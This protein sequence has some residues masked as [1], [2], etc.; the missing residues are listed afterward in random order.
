MKESVWRK[1]LCFTLAFALIIGMMPAIP[2]AVQK[3][4]ATTTIT[5][6]AVD[7]IAVPEIGETP[8]YTASVPDGAA[9]YIGTDITWT[10]RDVNG[11]LW[12]K[13]ENITIDKS[14]TF[15]ED[16]S[17]DVR[18][19][20][21]AKDGSTFAAKENLTVTINGQPAHI[22]DS[23]TEKMLYIRYTFGAPKGKELIDSVALT[24]EGHK[25]GGKVRG[26]TFTSND[27]IK[28]GSTYGTEENYVVYLSDTENPLTFETSVFCPWQQY[29]V[30]Y[31][32][33][34]M[35]GYTF[36]NFGTLMADEVTLN[37][38]PADSLTLQND[39]RIRALFALE[40][41]GYIHE[42]ELSVVKPAS[43]QPIEKPTVVSVNGDPN[44]NNLVSASYSKW[45]YSPFFVDGAEYETVSG[46]AF[47]D[48]YA[49]K[50]ELDALCVHDDYMLADDCQVTVK[51]SD[52]QV[53]QKG[54]SWYLDF[55][56]YR[57]ANYFNLNA[58]TAYDTLKT[59]DMEIYGY[60]GGA[61]LMNLS[62]KVTAN[63][64]TLMLPAGETL[65]IYEASFAEPEP[66][67]LIKYDTQ[68]IL[69]MPLLTVDMGWPGVG[70]V[71]DDINNVKITLHGQPLS[72]SDLMNME[73][74]WWV[75]YK[76]PILKEGVECNGLSH[77]FQD[78]VEEA[79]FEKDGKTYQ[80]CSKGCGTKVN[81]V[82]IPKVSIV[83]LTQT[84]FTYD[85]QNKKPAVVVK[86]SKGKALTEGV[87]YTVIYPEESK[88]AGTYAV[89]IV[90]QGNYEGTKTLS[91]MI[92][93]APS[94]DPGQ[95][96]NGSESGTPSAPSTGGG[97]TMP[98]APSQ[99]S[100][101]EQGG[102]QPDTPAAHQHNYEQVITKATATKDGKIEMKCACGDVQTTTVIAKAS[103]T[104]LSVSSYL[105]NG[106][107]KT[108]P[109]VIVKDSNGKTISSIYYKVS[110]PKGTLKAIGNYTY[111][112]TFKGDKYT[113]KQKLTLTIKPAKPTIQTPK[114]AKKAVSVKWKKVAKAQVTGYQ[115]M[116]AT[117]KKFTKNVNK[118]FVNG[119]NKTSKKMTKLKAK[120][121]YY[122]K[123]RTYK[124]VKGV[125]IYSDWSKVKTVKTK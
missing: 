94:S 72:N 25:L 77:D 26:L 60:N 66:P 125:K 45:S 12:I 23:S 20:I 18:M 47:Q 74:Y 62:A 51:T 38:K 8:D 106:K 19:E 22:Y 108:A 9:Y 104:K 117:N 123:V 68:Y 40:K 89:S 65:M 44:L 14:E 59:W 52:G 73:G 55:Q 83:Q 7:G 121:T 88:A 67:Y 13:E 98:S 30:G 36:G 85:G 57:Q 113:G 109:K 54:E 61:S 27:P 29:Y 115:V 15:S 58:P 11:I 92:E 76:L 16:G 99:P 110:K 78:I 32:L 101:P 122:V 102:Q 50:L 93:A 111:T 107:K 103:K 10:N 49:Y 6:V 90:L 46:G 69:T 17:Y 2:G 70:W 3:A 1:I 43:E 105:Y 91:Y 86:D 39:G 41:V 95:S 79:S 35:E 48:G 96:G 82:V 71:I 42:I 4:H 53:L 21:Y 80:Q 100:T 84:S 56:E 63:G 34:P 124:T 75:M 33:E 87:D 28:V 24:M 120:K 31:Y 5:E 112:I 119:Y 37:G 97:S 118:T 64:K 116:V 114:A 81:E